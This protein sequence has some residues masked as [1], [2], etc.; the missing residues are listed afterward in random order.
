MTFT[1]VMCEL[2]S[3]VVS[4]VAQ[5]AAVARFFASRMALKH[6]QHKASCYYDEINPQGNYETMAYT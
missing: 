5:V 2:R 3:T 1:K 4:T 6:Q